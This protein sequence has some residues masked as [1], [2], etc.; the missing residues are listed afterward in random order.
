MS[1]AVTRARARTEAPTGRERRRVKTPTVL[2]MEAVECGAA[3]LAIVLAHYGR[4][5]PLEELRAACGVSRDGSRASNILKAARAYGLEGKGMRM[6]PASLSGVRLPAILFWNFNHFLVIEG[7]NRKGVRLNDPASGQRTVSWQDFDGSFTGVVLVLEPTDRLER[8]G[9]APSVVKG[10][11]KRFHGGTAALVLCVLAGIGLLVPG[12]LVPASVRIFV[13][14]Y[15]EAG[16]RSWLWQ[17]VLAVGLAAVAQMAFTWLQQI[18]L[19]RLSTKLAMSMSTRFFEHVLRLPLAFFSQR[20]AGHVVTRVTVND[21]IASLLS[22]QLATSL[23]SLLTSAFFLV[24]M[25]IYDWQ[26]TLITITFA[27]INVIALQAVARRQR[28]INRRLVQDTGK[29]TAAAVSGLQNIETLKATSEDASFFSRWAGSQANVIDSM[30]SLGGPASG[31]ASLPALLTGANT[32]VILGFG[33][34]QVMD[35]TLS[36]GTLLAFQI[37]AGGFNGPIAQLVGF[38]AVLQQTAANLASVDDVLDYPADPEATAPRPATQAIEAAA[39]RAAAQGTALEGLGVQGMAVDETMV[40]RNGGSASS[41][42]NG[43][44]V[45][46]RN[47]VPKR[48][49]G[50]LELVDISFGY[51]P[52]GE[53]LVEGL[54]LRVEPGQRVALVG[55]TGSGKS[56]IARIVAGLNRPWGG[57]ILFD[58]IPREEISRD[59]LSVSVAFVDQDIQLFESSVHD[60]LT[61]WDPTV[62]EEIVVRGAR[63]ASIHDD[64]L[65]RPGGY[66]RIIDEGGRDWSGGQRQRLEI[67]RALTANPSLLIMDEATSALDPLVEQ[68]IDERVRARGCTC[69]IVAHR[70]S[71][72]RDCDEII[73]LEQG[74]PVERG[75][76]E[77]LA[78]RGGTYE[79]LLAE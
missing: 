42:S 26:L 66:D 38:G 29:L 49:S 36:L 52:L 65:R 9:S 19:L 43:S 6:E 69:L 30:Q 62:P 79:E 35:G 57:Q 1:V 54:S 13:N 3:A 51:N 48:L 10:L 76:H 72:I 39:V 70:L 14:E 37:L 59:V 34:W 67:A 55:P 12:L 61:L 74:K 64:I 18:T 71:T 27:L 75:T 44:A 78:A 8:A 2:Q 5:V 24:L 46:S 33:G 25:F 73:V 77:E 50:A 32:A 11:R 68:A 20:Y 40:A 60:N 28:D 17:L 15:L 53:P 16:N 7:Y 41:G 56:T 4:W 31:L 58:G 47:G 45:A 63:D 22:S 21:Q 23:L